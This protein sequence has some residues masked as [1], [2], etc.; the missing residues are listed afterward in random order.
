M[1]LVT[2]SALRIT[3]L[4]ACFGL[5]YWAGLRTWLL[6]VVATLAAWGL[7]YVLLAGPRDRAATYLAQRAEDRRVSGRRFSGSAES[8]AEHEDSVVDGASGTEP[9]ER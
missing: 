4:A 3:L 7:S 6:L 2:Y 8:D 9:R 5:G 1:P